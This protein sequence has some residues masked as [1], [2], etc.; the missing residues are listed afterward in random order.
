MRPLQPPVAG[1]S[2]DELRDYLN[3]TGQDD[4][5]FVLAVGWLLGAL[6]PGGPYPILVLSGEQGSAKTTTA[7]VLRTLV[8]PCVTLVRSEP[9]ETRDLM[10]AA[11]NGW[12]IAIDNMSSM[13]AWLSDALCRLST[14]GGFAT[15][16]LYTNDEEF[17]IEAQRP[18]ILN[19]IEEIATRGDLLDRSILLELPPVPEEKRRTEVEFWAEFSE[20]A[21]RIL[22]ALLDALVVAIRTA[23][24]VRL[25]RLPRM[26]DL[27]VWVTAGEVAFGWPAGTFQAAYDENLRAAHELALEASPIV[28]SLRDLV[29]A[30]PR[31]A[32][33]A[34]DLLSELSAGVEPQQRPHGWP[35]TPRGLGGMLR[36]LAPNL[37]D[38]GIDVAFSREPGKGRRRLI[39]LTRQGP[40]VIWGSTVPPVPT[41]PSRG[42][43]W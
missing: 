10:I 3:V 34:Q 9:R 4:P 31:W 37:R 41:V 11:R 17:F 28:R 14:G 23:P 12:V 39:T 33:T 24:T 32:G 42:R 25:D 15:R 36:R 13:P 20:A 8:D 16:Q 27:A 18:V 40:E 26:A 5:S 19:G 7:R 21:P 6:H 22:G 38:H 30:Q 1:G 35:R 2:I 43:P 29:A